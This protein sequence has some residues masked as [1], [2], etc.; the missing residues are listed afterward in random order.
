MLDAGLLLG[1]AGGCGWAMCC[2]AVC[3]VLWREYQ[4]TYRY[5]EMGLC[6]SDLQDEAMCPLVIAGK[7]QK[8]EG[9]GEKL[10][11]KHMIKV[12]DVRLREQEREQR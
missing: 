6:W 5:V 12:D 9:S 1:V 10:C 7:R 8:V 4:W 3:C 11:V 2:C